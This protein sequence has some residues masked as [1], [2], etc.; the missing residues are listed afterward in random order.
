MLVE[1]DAVRGR[2]VTSYGSIQTDL[3]NAGATWVERRF[4]GASARAGEGEGR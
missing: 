3:R 1:A 4:G 2:K